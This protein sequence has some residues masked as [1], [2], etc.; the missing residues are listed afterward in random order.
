M[1]IQLPSHEEIHAAFNEGEAAVFVLFDKAAQ[2]LVELAEQLKKQAELIKELQ[3]KAAKNSR[4]SSK[5][6]SSDG[7]G[8]ANKTESLRK[9]SERSN[10]GQPGHAGSTLETVESPDHSENHDP[11]Q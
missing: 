3:A 2:Q 7:Y 11:D 6:P 4:N 10:G 5:P 1:N 8:K 9:K